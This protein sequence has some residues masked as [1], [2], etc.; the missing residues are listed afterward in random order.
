MPFLTC[1]LT[2]HNKPQYLPEAINSLLAQTMEDW[3]TII[4]DSGVLHDQGFFEQL[5]VSKDPRFR[6]IRSWETEELRQTKTIAS[7]CTNECF[8][9]GLVQGKFVSY[10]CDDDLL[11]A[12]AFQAFYDFVQ[13]NPEVQAMYA[14]V[15]MTSVT[16]DG[17]EVYFR[18]S[19][20]S[21]MKGRCCGGGPLDYHVDYLQLCHSSD[22]LKQFPSN[23]YWPEDKD[24]IRHADGIFME[25]LG[26][27]VPIHPVPVKIGQNRK[28]P[29]SLNDGGERLILLQ[30]VARGGVTATALHV[31]LDQHQTL[32]KQHD[33]LLEELERPC[34]RL[35][36]TVD[37]SMKRLPVVHNTAERVLHATWL[38]WKWAKRL[39]PT[40]A[41]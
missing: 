28:V 9:Q 12:N 27:L 14:S 6:V 1:I 3:E 15:D 36:S 19:V 34:Y 18:E 39:R 22:V 35:V 21:E 38:A 33:R 41:K 13:T 11:Y 32:R 30:D 26:D 20:A 8:R 25:K 24:L 29:C 2:S 31:L 10:L 40:S 7:W 16:A 4:F 17:E 23:E 37:R 5:E